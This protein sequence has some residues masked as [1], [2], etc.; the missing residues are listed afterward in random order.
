MRRFAAFLIAALLAPGSAALADTDTT[1]PTQSTTYIAGTTDESLTNDRGYWNTA[2]VEVLRTFAP[3]S[4]FYTAINS[5][6]LYQKT[7]AQYAAGLY[8]PVSSRAVL[9][10]DVSWSPTHQILAKSD[11]ALS[12]EQRFGGGWGAIGSLETR[13]Y[14]S[15]DANLAALTIDR[16]VGPYRFA[17][18]VSSASLSDV[19]GEALTHDLIVQ[20]WFGDNFVGIDFEGGRDVENEG[21][22]GSELL[23]SGVGGASAFGRQW[24]DHNF[25]LDW[26]LETYRLGKIYTRNGGSIGVRYRR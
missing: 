22:G 21:T 20:R 19:P 9:G 26:R 4:T 3:R 1:P 17:Y 12:L 10:L 13:A 14:T 15:V 24:L 7:D 18:R 25:A 11:I 16:Y 5:Q 8:V 2:S 6:S 23:V